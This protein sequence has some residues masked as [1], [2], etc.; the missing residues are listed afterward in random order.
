MERGDEKRKRG[1]QGWP[2]GLGW[3]MTVLKK[4]RDQERAPRWEAVINWLIPETF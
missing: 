1:N 4:E 2:D 3:A